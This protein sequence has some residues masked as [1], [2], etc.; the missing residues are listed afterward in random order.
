MK[1]IKAIHVVH[2]SFTYWQKESEKT[3]KQFI[4]DDWFSLNAK[5]I[6]KFYPEIEIEC[7]CPE[8][9]YKKQ[10]EFFHSGIKY[11][12]FPTTLSLTYATDISIQM[13]K[14]LGK[15]IKKSRQ[16]NYKLII[17]LHEIHNIHGLLIATMFK[18]Q[19]II[20][21]HHGGS[22]PLKHLK[23]NKKFR[24]FSPFFILSQ[25]WENFALKNLKYYYAL[26]KEEIDYIKRKAPK[27]K[28]RFQTMG[29]DD[30]YFQEVSKKEAR[31]KL[32]F[33]F[34]KKIILYLGRL[35][36]VKGVNF[37]ID[38]MKELKDV[39]LKIIGYGPEEARL[40]EQA[41]KLKLKNIEFLGGI[42]GKDKLLYLSAAD[43]LILPSS[44][45]GAPVVVM[46][47]MA[48][49]LPSI[50]TNVGGVSLMIKQGVN[51]KIIQ[52]R[53]PKAIAHA[54]KEVLTWKNKNVKKYAEVYRWEKI[55]DNT[56][57]DYLNC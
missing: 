56:L 28:V 16:E 53:R 37:L 9:T 23:Q 12:Q 31:R 48:G 27:V 45:E 8:R 10:E 2:D 24:F 22:W 19:N 29:I 3:L 18:G 52:K 36:E 13:L 7:W 38:A 11:R 41:K 5:Q 49:N 15:E 20:V 42:F 47:A 55:I 32:K 43:A 1:K 34:N 33:P 30:F 50:V 46:E 40:K 25:L 57:K 54:V 14:E 44:K 17:H 6:K 39:E 51:G 35:H 4:I 21:Q 26:S